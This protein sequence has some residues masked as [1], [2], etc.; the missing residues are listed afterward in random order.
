MHRKD[1]ARGGSLAGEIRPKAKFAL[2]TTFHSRAIAIS[3][4]V[5]TLALADQ[6]RYSQ[7]ALTALPTRGACSRR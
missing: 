5:A 4:S 1:A 2:T 7:I 3:V 6:I